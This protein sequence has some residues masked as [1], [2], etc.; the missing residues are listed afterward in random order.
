M[1]HSVSFPKPETNSW[2]STPVDIPHLPR[3][4]PEAS[5]VPDRRFRHGID[6]PRIAHDPFVA[7]P[8]VRDR[9]HRRSASHP[10]TTS[11]MIPNILVPTSAP[12]DVHA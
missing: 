7:D 10:H 2:T 6:A 5:V 8:I 9:H 4:A 11:G 12:R 1:L 3:V